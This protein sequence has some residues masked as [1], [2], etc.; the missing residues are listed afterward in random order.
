ME[1]K[2]KISGFQLNSMINNFKDAE[3][4]IK[5]LEREIEYLKKQIRIINDKPS[6]T[7]VNIPNGSGLLVSSRK[8]RLRTA[9]PTSNSVADQQMVIEDNPEGDEIINSDGSTIY[10]RLFHIFRNLK[11]EI[12]QIAQTLF[13]TITVS[14]DI[15]TLGNLTSNI[16]SLDNKFG[17]VHCSGIDCT[18]VQATLN[19]SIVRNGTVYPGMEVAGENCMVSIAPQTGIIQ[20]KGWDNN[21]YQQ[22]IIYAINVVNRTA[23]YAGGLRVL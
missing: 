4:K 21:N 19:Y 17:N 18:G 7:A 8:I 5:S 22:E 1:R 12:F 14:G 13:E 23:Y 9:S 3:I 2:L 20:F 15:L 16:G 10:H 6:N 11:A